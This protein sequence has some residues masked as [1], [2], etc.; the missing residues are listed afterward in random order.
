MSLLAPTPTTVAALALGALLGC[1]SGV[2]RGRL[3][4]DLTGPD[5]GPGSLQERALVDAVRDAAAAEGLACQ[6]GA[7]GLLLRCSPA[8]FGSQGRAVVLELERTGSGYS[9]RAEQGIRLR[10]SEAACEVQRRVAERLGAAVGP[11]AVRVDARSDCKAKK[12]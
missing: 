1:A 2:P 9:V 8:T 4:V 7:G 3:R 5:A 6:P 10:R 11:Q 12:T